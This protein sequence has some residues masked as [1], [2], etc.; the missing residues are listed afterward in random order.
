MMLAV[1]SGKGGVGKTNLS[2]NLALSLAGFGKHVL[3]F[4]A[5]MGLANANILLGIKPVATLQDVIYGSTSLESVVHPGPRGIGII[6][7]GTGV[8]SLTDLPEKKVAELLSELEKLRM[9]YDYVIVDTAAGISSDVTA[10]ARASDY[11]LIVLCPEPAAFLDAYATVKVLNID[12]GIKNFHVV[13]NKVTNNKSGK[14]LFVKFLKVCDQFL[15]VNLFNSAVVP[16]DPRI[17]EAV[18]RKRSVVDLFP[19]APSTQGF[20]GLA[21]SIIE[22]RAKEMGTQTELPTNQPTATS[23]N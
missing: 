10:F 6:P 19:T 2:V 17:N 7:G 9:T 21:R 22:Y 15:K 11:P 1:T 12:F 5:D 8:V 23:R 13:S 16:D 20:L 4:D 3:L 14:E 18:N